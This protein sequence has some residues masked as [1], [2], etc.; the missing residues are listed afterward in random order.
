MTDPKQQNP[1]L[2]KMYL[3]KTDAASGQGIQGVEFSI[4][5]PNGNLYLTV[6]TGEDGYA[7]FDMPDNG[8]Y[9]YKETKSAPGYL[10]TDHTYAFTIKMER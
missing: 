4:Y 7:K 10:A 6:N 9:T 1:G 2:D 5:R 8:T 3:Y